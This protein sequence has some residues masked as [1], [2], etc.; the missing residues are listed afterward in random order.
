M[1]KLN[2]LLPVVRLVRSD[3]YH[4][5]PGEINMETQSNFDGSLKKQYVFSEFLEYQYSGNSI[6]SVYDNW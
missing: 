5:R 4:G 1:L 6:Y 2:K 3:D